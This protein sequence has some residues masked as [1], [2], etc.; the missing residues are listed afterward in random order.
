MQTDPTAR[1]AADLLLL[2]D[3]HDLS[4]DIVEHE[5]VFT[6]ADALAATPEIAGIQTKNV[7]PGHRRPGPACLSRLDWA[8]APG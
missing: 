4:Y 1:A 2:L 5:P 6:I 8:R 3:R 7:F